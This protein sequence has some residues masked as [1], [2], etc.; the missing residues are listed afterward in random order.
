MAKEH[1]SQ[2]SFH[3]MCSAA[4]L[5]AV[6]TVQPQPPENGQSGQS[7]QGDIT[8][9]QMSHAYASRTFNR[10]ATFFMCVTLQDWDW[11]MKKL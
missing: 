3:N 9:V 1:I 8:Y 11:E 2:V 4:A 6:Q 5:L 10:E 7:S